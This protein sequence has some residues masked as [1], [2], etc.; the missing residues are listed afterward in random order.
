M[1]NKNT[2]LKV[3]FKRYKNLKEKEK[4]N[5]SEIEIAI[6]DDEKIRMDQFKLEEYQTS[7]HREAK[8]VTL[9]AT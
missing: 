6:C 1:E 7:N 8:I 2:L 9:K 3:L 5:E 4:Q